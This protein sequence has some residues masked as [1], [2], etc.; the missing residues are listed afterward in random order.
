MDKIEVLLDQSYEDDYLMIS[1]IT[2]NIAD[3]DEKA[4]VQ[5]IAKKLEGLFVDYDRLLRQR[6]ADR[7]QVDVNLIELDTNDIDLM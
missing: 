1:T 3:N 2:V 6:V 4:R 5:A 7:L